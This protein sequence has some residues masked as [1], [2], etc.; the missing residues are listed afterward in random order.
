[1]DL[2][3]LLPFIPEKFR[4]LVVALIAL[5]PVIGRAIYA[6]KNDGGI[7]GIF[8]SIWLGT[9]TPKP[10]APAP[11]VDP[12]ATRKLVPLLA[13]FIGLAVLSGCTMAQKAAARADAQAAATVI[14]QDVLPIVANAAL[15]ELTGGS[16]AFVPAL[17]AGLKSLVNTSNVEGV[18]NAATGNTMPATVAQLAPLVTSPTKANAIA[19]VI[20]AAQISGAAVLKP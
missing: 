12:N 16:A 13:A 11:P 20:D 4:A 18:L 17:S 19:A 10:T 6:V 14:G 3:T 9:N 7:K 1:M 5:S 2:N 8:S 15:A